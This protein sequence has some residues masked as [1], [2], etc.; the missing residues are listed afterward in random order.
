MEGSSDTVCAVVVTHNRRALLEECLRAVGAQTRRPDH[1]LVVDNA[2]TDGTPDLVRSR[3]PDTELV[4]LTENGGGAGGF[5]AGMRAA[6][7][8]GFAW[9]WLMDDDTIPAPDALERLLAPLRDLGGLPR[10]DILASRVVWSDGDLHP[11]NLPFPRV[12][13]PS[14]RALVDAAAHGLL[15]IRAATFVSILVSAAAI[16]RHGLPHAHYFTWGDD[17][18]FTA[19]VLRDGAGYLVPGSVVHHKTAHKA[20]VFT[21]SPQYYYELRNK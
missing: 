10:P 1:V 17:G 19:R 5:H 9:L 14:K 3:Y 8:R 11:K 6:H 18:E 2:S 7:E 12:D 16:D 20:S 15:L 21:A 13:D 4:A